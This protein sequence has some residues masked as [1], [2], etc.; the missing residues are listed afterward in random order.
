MLL[1][2]PLSFLRKA[3]KVLNSSVPPSGVAAAFALGVLAG[4]P[5]MGLHIV[6]PCTAALLFRTSFRGFLLSMAL[7]KLLSLP[8]APASFA[9]GRFLLDGRRGLDPLWRWIVHQPVLAPMGYGR[10]L[11]L[12][13]LVIALPLAVAVFV[14]VRLLVSRYRERFPAWAGTLRLSKRLRSMRGAR[15]AR[16][17]LVGGEAKHRDATPPRGVFR[18]VRKEMLVALP[19]VYAACYLLAAAL[20]PLLAGGLATS[21]ASWIAGTE[22][23]VERSAFSLFTGSLTLDGLTI[24]DPQRPEENLVVVPSLRLDA[25]MWPLVAKRVVFNAVEIQEASLHVVREEDGTLNIDNAGTGWDA[26]GYLAWAEASA[27]QVDWL[28]LLRRFLDHLSRARPLAPRDDPLARFRGGRSFAPFRPAFTVE[29]IAIGRVN[30]TLEDVRPSS[31]G[32]PP[33]TLIEVELT[34]VA[35]P[36]TLSE[37]P[38]DLALRGRFGDSSDTGFELAARFANDGGKAVRTYRIEATRLDLAA[39]AAAYETTLPAEIVSGLATVEA[40]FVQDGDDAH[41]NASILIEDLRLAPREGRTLFALSPE[42]SQRTIDGLNRY[43]ETFPVVLGVGIG[44]AASAPR[45][46][47][48][49]AVLDLARQGLL[50]SGVRSLAPDA[51]RLAERID[52]LGGIQQAPIAAGYDELRDEAS[53]AALDL[54]RGAAPSDAD[55]DPETLDT[56]LRRLFAAPEEPED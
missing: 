51:E 54:I 14:L 55:A 52:A 1:P 2:T 33:L 6:L 46:D 48:E 15:L 17:L 53:R 27:Q 5:P 32:L 8:L 41:G 10:Y 35:F 25:G 22:V 45:W 50:L 19:V 28:G 29:R 49:A 30:V 21:T 3:V 13:S 12:G 40:T 44:G 16:R 11:L 34:N 9:L 56:L 38:V 7:F 20:V 37:E 42:L 18:V 39:L 43:A 36:A 47:W 24:Q 26:E 4:L 31:S 23:D